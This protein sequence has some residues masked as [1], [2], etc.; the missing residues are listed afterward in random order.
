MNAKIGVAN[1]PCSWGVTDDF[2]T[3]APL[4]SYGQVLDEIA[5]AGYTGTEFGDWGFLPADPE[6]LRSEL[7]SRN[8]ALVGAFVPVRLRDPAAHAGGEELAVR[9]AKLLV[10][11]APSS[12]IPPVIVLADDASDATRIKMA[13]RIEQR[14]G[15]DDEQWRNTAAGAER[16]ARAVRDR[17]GLRTAFHHHSATFVET[18]DELA[19]L[20]DLTDP[21]V[22]GVCLDTGH[23]A[24]GGGDPLEALRQIGARVWHV[25]VKDCDRSVLDRMRSEELDYFEAVNSRVFCELGQGVVDLASIL[26]ELKERDYRGW[27]VVED[28][29]PPGMGVPLESAR[30]DREFLRSF[31]L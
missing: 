28:E 9:T 15:L 11:S 21:D 4:P 18:A 24:Y 19:T 17:T 29:V 12:D 20:L 27:I 26:A 8:L 3:D 2:Q 31:G 23:Y 30:R 16:I 25:H 10:D 6:Q 13:G 1:A 14:H 5:L 7:V 22:L